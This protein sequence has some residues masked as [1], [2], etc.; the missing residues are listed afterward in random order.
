[1]NNLKRDIQ[2]VLRAVWR[3]PTLT[4]VVTLTLALGV[5]ATTAIFSV[6]DLVVLRPLPYEASNRLVQLFDAQRDV[7]E[8]PASYPEYLD[9]R[10]RSAD[11]F[12]DIG[13]V[14]GQGE[15]LSGA[16]D[17]E[18]L[19]GAMTSVN[20]PAL[21]G[22]GGGGTR[23]EPRGHV[24][25]RALAKA[26]R[27]RSGDHRPDGDAH[28]WGVHRDRHLPVVVARHL[29]GALVVCPRQAG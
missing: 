19:Q 5:G 29:A 9:W 26:L 15:V 12:S 18:Q 17:A 22:C 6:L 1:M 25:R 10:Q 21:L 28:G 4:V 11:V 23:R 8:L 24:E 7:R 3:T 13:V 27:R 14:I 20:V 16:G 2:Q